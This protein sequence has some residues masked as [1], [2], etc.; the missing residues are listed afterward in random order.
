LFF[1]FSGVLTLKLILLGSILA[2][3]N[4]VGNFF[5]AKFFDPNKTNQ[6]RLFAY[7]IIAVAAISGL[8]IWD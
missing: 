6:Y 1:L 5:G 8:P 3:P 7:I 2:I 4:F